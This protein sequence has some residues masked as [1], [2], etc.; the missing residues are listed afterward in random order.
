MLAWSISDSIGVFDLRSR[1]W[2]TLV[3]GG[4][5]KT[6]VEPGYL[7]YI[8]GPSLMAVPFHLDDLTLG[9]TPTPIVEVAAGDVGSFAVGGGTLVYQ[10]LSFA[11]TMALRSSAGVTRVLPSTPEGLNYM[12]PAVS[13]DGRRL[14]ARLQPMNTGGA[15]AEIWTYELP[16]GPFTRLT[17]VDGLDTS[18]TW[19]LD[20]RRI[21]Y[22]SARGGKNSALYLQ[23]WDGSGAAELILRRAGHIWQT[24]WLPD[25]DRFVF[26]ESEQ[27]LS[28]TNDIY[29]SSLSA[30]DSV[31]PLVVSRF[32]EDAP[33]VSPDGRWLAYHSDESGRMEVYV[34]P[35][36]GQGTRRQV[37]RLGGRIP[38]WGSSGRELF[39]AN[40]D[41]LYAARLDGRDEIVVRDIRPLFKLTAQIG[42]AVLPGDSL[43]VVIEPAAGG[44]VLRPIVAVLNFDQVLKARFGRRR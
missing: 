12:A 28:T 3:R 8:E 15:A 42:Y 23:P 41:S 18:P 13:P 4:V 14:A 44:A 7:L 9:G 6:Y 2:R 22:S 39:F 36:E 20:G 35:L 16:T 10:F 30:P 25:G 38:A 21:L 19:T 33:V 37:S 11:S 32:N 26:S 31:R 1:A 29:L 24:S 43:F 5:F 17:F 40:R 27:A 34:R